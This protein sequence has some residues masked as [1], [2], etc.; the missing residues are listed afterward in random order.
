M[1]YITLIGCLASAANVF[2][3]YSNDPAMWGWLS[4][5]MWAGALFVSELLDNK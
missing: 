4:S 1:K 2:I 3:H 5:A